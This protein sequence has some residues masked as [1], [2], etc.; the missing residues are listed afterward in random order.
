MKKSRSSEEQAI[1]VLMQHQ[2][3]I[4]TAELRRKRGISETTF[5]NW[6]HRYGGM[7]ASGAPSWTLQPVLATRTGS[8]VAPIDRARGLERG[9][10]V[11]NVFAID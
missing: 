2:A 8:T 5:Y 3:S 4:P 7:E 11:S 1:G 6:R 10:S 9:A